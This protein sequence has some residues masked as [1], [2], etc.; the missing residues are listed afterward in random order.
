[1]DKLSQVLLATTEAAFGHTGLLFLLART[2]D[3][4]A[5]V[6][7]EAERPRR[8]DRSGMPSIALGRLGPPELSKLLFEA[9]LLKGMDLRQRDRRLPDQVG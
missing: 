6:R 7:A 8:R 2:P 9:Q 4:P 3:E 5:A 1:M